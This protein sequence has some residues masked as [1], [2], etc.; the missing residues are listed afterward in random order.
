MCA[1]PEEVNQFSNKKKRGQGKL[2]DKD[3][4]ICRR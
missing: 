1:T 4:K 3:L 2:G